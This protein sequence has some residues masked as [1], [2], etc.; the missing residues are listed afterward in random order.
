MESSLAVSNWKWELPTEAQWEFACR[1][2]VNSGFNNGKNPSFS[3][4][5]FDK[6]LSEIA[7]YAGNN[8]PSGTKDVARK[9]PNRWGLYDMEGNVWE[10]LYDYLRSYTAAAENSPDPVGFLSFSDRG[11]RGGD[12]NNNASYCR[13]AG[14]RRNYRVSY[15]NNNIGLR[16]SL[17]PVE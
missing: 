3:D 12:Y 6:N 1:A 7:W 15:V 17:Q 9:L 11:Y 8:T 4:G 2:G 13:C 5:T 14:S 16:P 10:W